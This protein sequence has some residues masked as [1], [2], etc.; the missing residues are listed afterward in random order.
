M[1][2]VRIVVCPM[3]F[4]ELA[5]R[6]LELAVHVSQALGARL[7]LHHNV[8]A[9]SPAFAKAW[10]WDQSHQKD[11]RSAADAERRLARLME[12][13]PH[14]VHAEAVLTHGPLATV[15][16]A[17]AEKIPA[18]LLV[19]GTHGWS[20]EDHASITERIIDRTPCPVLTIRDGAATQGF[21][22]TA[23]PDDPLVRVLVPTDFSPSATR[24]V[25]F[26]I[27]LARQLPL[28]LHLVHVS[29]SAIADAALATLVAAVP[30]ELKSRTLCHTRVGPTLEEI[31]RLLRELRPQLIIMGTHARSFWRRLFRRD[32]ARQVLHGANCPV[33][34]VPPSC[35]APA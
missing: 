26:A 10:E 23:G 34:F 9:V 19:L 5:D 3:D 7:V 21:R 15:L 13:L 31:D 16:L 22:L 4:S 35:A 17:L 8:S 2:P 12:R 28:E 14:G 25:D 6:E 1:R 33:C 18:D 29:P 20:S 24:A 32:I 30:S 27:E 11:E